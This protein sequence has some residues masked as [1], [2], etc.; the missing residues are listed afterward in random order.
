MAKSGAAS[1]EAYLE[2]LS[3]ERRETLAG[4]RETILESLPE[5]YEEGMEFGMISYHVPLER[6]PDTYNGRP[7]VVAGLAS[8]KNYVSLY[9]LGVCY[10][11][12]T[13]RWFEERFRA[14][15]KKLDMGR[16][17]VRFKKLDDLPLALIGE[18]IA[19]VSPGDLIGRYEASRAG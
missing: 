8:Q 17:C 15:G 7:L 13:E 12:E 9:L 11:P 18:A 5:G 19:R 4:V 14:S 6:Y 10:D 3:P 2:E 16:S 1:P